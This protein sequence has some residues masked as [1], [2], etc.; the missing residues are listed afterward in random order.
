MPARILIVLLDG[1]VQSNHGIVHVMVHDF[2]WMVKCLQRLQ[3]K[4]WRRSASPLTNHNNILKKVRCPSPKERGGS[5]G[6]F[7]F[8]ILILKAAILIE[9]FESCSIF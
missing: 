5:V 1:I 8:E 9:R 4:I 2:Q 3:E 7:R 6:S